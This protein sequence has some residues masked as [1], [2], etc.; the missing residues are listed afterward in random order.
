LSFFHSFGSPDVSRSIHCIIKFW[1]MSCFCC[2]A[3][4]FKGSVCLESQPPQICCLKTCVSP[5]PFDPPITSLCMFCVVD[6]GYI[7]AL[8][9]RAYSC[10][11][12]H[13]IQELG[14][15]TS[16]YFGT[17]MP[18]WQASSHSTVGLHHRPLI[19]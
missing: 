3:S 19:G 1:S 14:L 13:I 9:R 10:Q 11:P 2:C 5:R 17:C 7:K 16:Q 15:E 18:Q 8:L 4:V 6:G 12:Q